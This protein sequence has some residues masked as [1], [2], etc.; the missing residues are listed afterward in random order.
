MYAVLFPFFFALSYSFLFSIPRTPGITPESIQLLPRGIG[1][2]N[3]FGGFDVG[4]IA[5]FTIPPHDADTSDVTDFITNSTP[6]NQMFSY[7][8]G[9]QV[10]TELEVMCVVSNSEFNLTEFAPG[11]DNVAKLTVWNIAPSVPEVIFESTFSNKFLGGAS[12]L[13]HCV[14][15]PG[16]SISNILVYVTETVQGRVYRVVYDAVSTGPFPVP[17]IF[18][19]STGFA[20]SQ[21]TSGFP[22]PGLSGISY[23]TRNT[24]EPFA[25]VCYDDIPSLSTMFTIDLTLGTVAEVTGAKGPMC[26][27]SGLK[28]F[29][30]DSTTTVTSCVGNSTEL[31]ANFPARGQV[32]HSTDGWRSTV[33]RSEHVVSNPTVQIFGTGIAQFQN[34]V[35]LL[36]NNA[37]QRGDSYAEI[38]YTPLVSGSEKLVGSFV[39]LTILLVLSYLF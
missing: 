34:S 15:V 10:E 20:G 2:V 9:F 37:F 14:I 4:T 35:F 38:V 29:D 1:L 3:S 5:Q 18:A 39:S 22:F 17:T 26:M 28:V 13:S 27:C 36:T 19:E 33:L 11:L 24:V 31:D 32:W 25:L 21:S 8:G 23:F 30:T 12:Y 16:V 6:G 7:V